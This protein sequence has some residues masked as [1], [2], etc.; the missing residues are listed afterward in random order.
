MDGKDDETE[1]MM[2]L[3]FVSTVDV[4]ADFEAACVRGRLVLDLELDKLSGSSD[5]SD[6]S[7]VLCGATLRFL[8]CLGL[9]G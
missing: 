4:D 1:G 5:S 2:V 3:S 8:C 9:V 6:S 7:T